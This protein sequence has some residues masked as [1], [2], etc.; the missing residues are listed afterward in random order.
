MGH[1]EYGGIIKVSY[2]RI[3]HKNQFHYSIVRR[4]EHSEHNWNILLNKNR[5]RNKPATPVRV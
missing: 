5:M 2:S 3:V 1:Y 4:G